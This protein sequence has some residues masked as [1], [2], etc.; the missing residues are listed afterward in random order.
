MVSFTVNVVSEKED[1]RVPVGVY[2]QIMVDIQDLFR[3]IGEYIVSKEMRLQGAVPKKLSDKFTLYIDSGKLAISASS[4]RPETEGYGNVV[5]DAVKVTEAVLDTL[6]SGTGGY[7]VEDNFKDALYRNQIVFDVVGLYQDLADSDGC[8]LMYGSGDEP[9]KFGKVDVDKMAKFISDR[10]LSVNGV[11]VGTVRKL[12]N[13]SK[14]DKYA[15]D[16]GTDSIRLTFADG[17]DAVPKENGPVI[18]AG[19][20]V[21]SEDGKLAAV[22]NAY[23]TAPLSMI[24]FGRMVSASGDIALKEPVEVSVAFRDGKWVF[25]NDELGILESDAEWDSASAKFHDYFVFLWTEYTEKKD[26]DLGDEEKEV[27]NAL[28]RLVA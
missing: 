21:Y 26:E 20:L 8:A 3:H 16:T 11:T 24:K 13:K 1:K 23:E 9:K 25:S 17:K 6:G 14:G 22:E 10:G 28:L 4:Y 27:K 18:V 12:Q 7:W 5:E 15:L 2:G 19:T